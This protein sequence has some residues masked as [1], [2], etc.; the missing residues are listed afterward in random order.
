MVDPNLSESPDA[1]RSAGKSTGRPPAPPARGAPHRSSRSSGASWVADGQLP[2][3]VLVERCGEDDP[4]DDLDAAPRYELVAR[5]HWPNTLTWIVAGAFLTTIITAMFVIAFD[6]TARVTVVSALTISVTGALV[7]LALR[8][9]P[10]QPRTGRRNTG[11][12]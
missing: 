4:A 2:Q 12:D 1:L 11:K 10:H 3:W 6:A 9:L 5:S 8:W 7:R